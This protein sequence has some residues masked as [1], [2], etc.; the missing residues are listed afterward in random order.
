MSLYFPK[1]KVLFLHIPKTGGTWV[2]ESAKLCG[3]E[4]NRS[5]AGWL[6][7]YPNRKRPKMHS[8][9]GHFL[10]RKQQ[11]FEKI[12]TNV[13]HPI[14]FYESMWKEF[15]RLK[16]HTLERFKTWWPWHPRTTAAYWYQ[17]TINNSK[18]PTASFDD[19]VTLMLANEPMWYTRLIEQYVGPEGGEF[20]D[21]IGRTETLL[22]D[23]FEAMVLFGYG[24]E[25][26]DN[27]PKL[28]KLGK[29]NSSSTKIEWQPDLKAEVEE[30]ERLVI[31]RFYGDNIGK[32]KYASLAKEKTS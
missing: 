4:A 12:Y 21:Y 20:C 9:L 15:N 32:C 19:W 22:T 13:R 23:F 31:K 8:L 29:L 17:Q 1:S 28:K 11:F 24:K 26:S 5:V 16:P 18:N 30:T 27:L 14:P 25:V 10:R 7:Q 6:C 2:E 3:I